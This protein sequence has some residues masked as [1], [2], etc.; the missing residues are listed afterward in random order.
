MWHDA[1]GMGWWMVWGSVMM[2]LFWGGL[3]ALIVWGVQSLGRRDDSRGQSALDIAKERLA[4][5]EITVQEFEQ[6]NETLKGNQ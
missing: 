6:I 2:I 4:R 5:G 3:V 1:D